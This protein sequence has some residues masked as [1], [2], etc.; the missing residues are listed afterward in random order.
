MA[1][2]EPRRDDYQV[3]TL[4][5]LS[6]GAALALRPVWMAAAG[7]LP[8]CLW[9][10][11]TGLPCPGC[12]TTR[13]LVRVLHGDVTAGFLLNPL[14]SCAACV[15]VVAGLSAPAWLATGG[16]VP[17]LE[18]RPRPVALAAATALIVLNWAWLCASGV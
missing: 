12:G 11:W 16:L 13:A 10:R 2:R 18:S 4:W 5:G 15:F 9:H 1:W 8:S 3:A 14:A 7:L 17:V 6:A